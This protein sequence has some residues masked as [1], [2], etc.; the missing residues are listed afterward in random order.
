M[1][2]RLHTSAVPI[3]CKGMKD[4]GGNGVSFR[5]ARYER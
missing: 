4:R 1:S 2:D 5:L 3:P